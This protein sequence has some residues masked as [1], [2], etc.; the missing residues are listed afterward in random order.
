MKNITH[1]SFWN[2]YGL[3]IA[4]VL[5]G[6]IFLMGCYFKFFDI[7]STASYIAIVGFP[8]PLILAWVAAFFELFLGLA[9]ITGFW[10]REAV[11]LAGIYIIFLAFAFHGPSLWADQNQFGFFVDHFTTLAGLLFMIAHGPGSKWVLKRS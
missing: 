4:R 10:F 8:I 11:F 7:N 1:A 6:G 2:T 3:V 5:M 9:I